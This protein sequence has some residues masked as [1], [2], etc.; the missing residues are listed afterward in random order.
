[1][2]EAQRAGHAES[3][4]LRDEPARRG[5]QRSGGGALKDQIAFAREE[6]FAAAQEQV[7]TQRDQARLLRKMLSSLV[8]AQEQPLPLAGAD[9]AVTSPASMDHATVS[10]V[11][12][13][14]SMS[15]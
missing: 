6:R 7:E 8:G 13:V 3:R 12:S 15:R 5:G 14:L 1:A 4:E 2:R 11:L 9:F 10:G